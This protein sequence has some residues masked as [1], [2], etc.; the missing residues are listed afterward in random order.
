MGRIESSVRLLVASPWAWPGGAKWC[1]AASPAQTHHLVTITSQSVR[2]TDVLGKCYYD[3][4]I[5]LKHTGVQ[6]PV[7]IS[8]IDCP[9]QE[10]SG[11]IGVVSESGE[12][13]PLTIDNHTEHSSV[14]TARRCVSQ[15]YNS[16][17]FLGKSGEASPR[18]SVG[19]TVPH[20]V[21]AGTSVA[22]VISTQLSRL[23]TLN[24]ALDV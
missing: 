19:A 20:H 11:I 22:G 23:L 10:L 7:N 8:L 5:T 17:Y 15:R 1:N 3:L 6:L 24:S 21:S 4:L 2:R 12:C 14:H 9:T 18:S 13:F 16:G